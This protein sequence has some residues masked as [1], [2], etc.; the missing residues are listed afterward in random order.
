MP[1]NSSLNANRG[2]YEDTPL[3]SD[4]QRQPLMSVVIPL[5]NKEK[6]VLRTLESLRA[7]T[8]KDFEI[9]MVNDGSKDRSVEVVNS[10]LSMHPLPNF[11]LISQTNGGTASARNLGIERAQGKYI[12]FLDAD[13]EW[14]P[15][16]L[17]AVVCLIRKYPQ[18][19][20][21]GTAYAYR[22]P[23]RMYEADIKGFTF[24]GVEG[25]MANY[26]EV[27]NAGRPPLWTSAVTA[28]KKALQAVGGFPSLKLG[29]DI[30]T[31]AKLA[32]DYQ[33]AYRREALAIYNR[34][35]ESYETG[36]YAKDALPSP[37]ADK[38]GE[39]L[40]ELL[41]RY[42][43]TV[44]LKRYVLLWHK[45][46]LVMLVESNRRIE[47]WQEWLRT[48][49]LGL[50]NLDCYYRLCLSLLPRSLRPLLKRLVGKY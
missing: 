44:G 50:Y 32:C 10:F 34:L 49:P 36:S 43:H 28:S 41:R 16:Y 47:V 46:R 15:T 2:G 3:L 5:Y 48:W 39:I 24:E 42:P 4:A 8:Y 22:E 26:F 29:E 12:A 20:V 33:I 31:W 27:A 13:D 25:V 40:G 30:V 35:P 45:M 21:F 9:V 38:G 14:Q 11:H 7:Q 37:R 18:C 23:D 6:I 1:I 17:E 19:D